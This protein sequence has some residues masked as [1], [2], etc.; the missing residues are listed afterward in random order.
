[1]QPIVFNLYKMAIHVAYISTR[2]CS[3]GIFTAISR[4]SA[5]FTSLSPSDSLRL[6]IGACP[7]LR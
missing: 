2:C 7:Q 3:W 4:T 6:R 5:G 1:M